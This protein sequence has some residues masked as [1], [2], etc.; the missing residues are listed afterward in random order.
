MEED[1]QDADGHNEAH[2][3]VP[4]AEQREADSTVIGKLITDYPP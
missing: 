4:D 3:E 2:T 1:K